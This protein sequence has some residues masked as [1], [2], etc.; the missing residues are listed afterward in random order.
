MKIGIKQRLFLVIV[1]TSFLSVISMFMV[2]QWSLDRGFLRYANSLEQ[3]RLATLVETLE[4]SY[5]RE[6]SWDFLK[7]APGSW[8]RLCPRCELPLRIEGGDELDVLH[9]DITQEA[10]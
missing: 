6:G 9:V 1:A 5:A 4:R 10:P 8:L 7:R 3:S 2:L